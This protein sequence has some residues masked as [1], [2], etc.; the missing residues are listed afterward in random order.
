MEII[1]LK[2]QSTNLE[3]PSYSSPLDWSEWEVNAG[4]QG[5][6]I[7]PA[8]LIATSR[9]W[10]VLLSSGPCLM[11]GR[12]GRPLT[13]K[14]PGSGSRLLLTS[15]LYKPSSTSPAL[16]T[17]MPVGHPLDQCCAR[18]SSFMDLPASLLNNKISTDLW[19][20]RIGH[21]PCMLLFVLKFPPEPAGFPLGLIYCPVE[22]VLL[23]PHDGVAT[24]F[25]FPLIP[26]LQIPVPPNPPYY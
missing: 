26:I 1:P 15:E 9:H 14:A 5:S 2:C 17:L 25:V 22:R 18:V 3:M 23:S 13:R 20:F 11:C 6:G 21:K 12:V 8:T 19:H 4:N 7:G 16:Q 24:L 10:R